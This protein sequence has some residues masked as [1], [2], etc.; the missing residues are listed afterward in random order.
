MLIAAINAKEK[1]NVMCADVPN[2]FVQTDMPIKK[3]D[4]ERVIM[5]ITGVLVSMLTKLDPKMY[6]GY[7]VYEKVRKVL[8]V[9]VLKAIYGMLQAALLWYKKFRSELENE[10]FIFNKYDPCI[11]NQM[12]NGSQHTIVFHVDDIMS[13]HVDKKVND[14]FTKWLE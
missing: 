1:R 8:Y 12:R 5:K 3:I 6:K 9:E 13:S 4:E 2:A 14:R 11:A 7:I 10:G